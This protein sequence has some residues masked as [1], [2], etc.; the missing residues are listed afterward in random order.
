MKKM[1]PATGELKASKIATMLPPMN[2]PNMGI[3]LR[4]PVISPNGMARPE[5]IKPKIVERMSTTIV[6]AQ[7]LMRETVRAPVT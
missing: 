6:V 5:E 4:M 2:E 7:P 1:M 3:R